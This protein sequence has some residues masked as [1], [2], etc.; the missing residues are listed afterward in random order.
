[1]R[2]FILLFSLV[3]FNCSSKPKDC[4]DFKT[5]TFWY[6]YNK[7]STVVKR[8][9]SIQVEISDKENQI[10]TGSIKWLS[11]CKYVLTYTDFS[12]NPN[13]KRIGVIIDVDILEVSGEKYRYRAYNDLKSITG[14]M[15][16]VS[17]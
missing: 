15:I 14:W 13:D 1:M 11:D 7:S 16:K 17:D 5:G 3:V 4:S 10:I 2:Y 8:N 12:N 6:L 9:D